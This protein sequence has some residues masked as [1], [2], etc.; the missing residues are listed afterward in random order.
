MKPAL[1]VVIDTN[2]L[3]SRLLAPQSVPARAVSHAVRKGQLLM[4]DATFEELTEVISRPKF[5]QY[6]TPEERQK[7]LRLLHRIAEITRITQRVSDC[8]DPEDNK[9]LELAVSGKAHVIITGDS[10]LLALHP[11]REIPI[12]KPAEYLRTRIRGDV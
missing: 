10:D 12:L 9:F 2:V 1:R 4:S 5:D 3:I 6:I 7:F 11:F 8:P